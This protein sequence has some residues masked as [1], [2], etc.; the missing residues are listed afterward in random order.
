MQQRFVFKKST[1]I[2]AGLQNDRTEIL[3]WNYGAIDWTLLWVSGQCDCT[4]G[5]K[6]LGNKLL[7][8]FGELMIR[9]CFIEVEYWFWIIHSHFSYYYSLYK[10]IH[11]LSWDSGTMDLCCFVCLSV[12]HKCLSTI[13]SGSRYSCYTEMYQWYRFNTPVSIVY[14]LNKTI[15]VSSVLNFSFPNFHFI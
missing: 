8:F 2:L 1:R 15:Q 6:Y 12:F 3:A 4:V 9:S 14:C 7:P 13:G 11:E 5:K 10:V